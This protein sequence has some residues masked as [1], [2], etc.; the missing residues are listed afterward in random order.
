VVVWAAQVGVSTVI[1]LYAGRTR[2]SFTLQSTTAYYY[3]GPYLTIPASLILFSAWSK[4]R[5]L[6]VAVLLAVTISLW[7]LLTVRRG[8]RVFVLALAQPLWFMWYLRRGRRPRLIAIL[9]TALVVILATNVLGALRYTE[10]RAQ[11]GVDRTIVAAIDNP[12]HELTKFITGID[13]SMFTVLE[14]EAHQYALHAVPHYPG[15]TVTSLLTGWI[16][17]KLF[18]N[19]PR[20]PDALLDIR[21]FRTIGGQNS[22]ATSLFGAAFADYG[23]PML[24]ATSIVVGILMRAV[25]EYF[26]RYPGLGMQMFFAAASPLSLILL[27]GDPADT[28]GRAVFLVVP[29]VLCLVLCSRP[30][31]KLA[32]PLEW[33]G[34]RQRPSSTPARPS[35]G[36]SP[37][38]KALP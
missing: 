7:L 29:L 8:D 14:I 3:L 4:R 22:F 23:W 24:V 6:G 27:R 17:R 20:A 35:S 16:P 15:T 34:R 31:L 2:T 32:S 9:A 36:A 33:M 18:P 12:G 10:T 30:P 38:R 37:D 11:R 5:T 1:N 21:L 25:W 28:L 19:K 26:L 13:T